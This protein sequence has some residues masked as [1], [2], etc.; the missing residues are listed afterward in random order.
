MSNCAIQYGENDFPEEIIAEGTI[1]TKEFLVS[2]SIF[3]SYCDM[4][5][6][7]VYIYMF[8][9]ICIYMYTCACEDIL[10]KTLECW[11]YKSY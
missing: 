8:I 3:F 1:I 4:P 11:T 6:A 2:F 9:Y 5:K 10:S 7:Y